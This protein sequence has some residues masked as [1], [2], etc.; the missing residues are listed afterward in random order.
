VKNIR[1]IMAITGCDEA[2]ARRI[3]ERMAINGL[4]FSECTKAAFRR[5]ALEAAGEVRS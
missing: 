2:T 1:D 5:A 3:F 4:D